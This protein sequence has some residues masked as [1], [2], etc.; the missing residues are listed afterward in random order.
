MRVFRVSIDYGKS[1]N[2]LADEINGFGFSFTSPELL[3]EQLLNHTAEVESNGRTCHFLPYGAVDKCIH[4]SA[5]KLL[6]PLDAK[7]VKINLDAIE[8]EKFQHPF[9][10]GAW[11]GVRPT[12]IVEMHPTAKVTYFTGPGIKEKMFRNVKTY[13]FEGKKLDKLTLFWIVS[14]GAE[15]FATDQFEA[16]YR[17]AGLTGL[18]FV[19]TNC[20]IV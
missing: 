1:G 19:D 5:I 16:A 13:V 15:L 4:E 9:N 10:E 6:P 8:M 12:Q 11:F 20:K 7:L 3:E 14:H 17:K 2:E 18:K